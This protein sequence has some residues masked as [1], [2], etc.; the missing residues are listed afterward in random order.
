MSIAVSV[1]VVPSLLLSRVFY[2]VLGLVAFAIPLTVFTNRALDA[3]WCLQ[4]SLIVTILV[5]CAFFAF[6]RARKTFH[7]DISGIGQIRLTQYSGVSIRNHKT[8]MP[9]DGPCSD[10]VQLTP[11]SILW[12]RFILLR[13]KL[14]DGRIVAIPVLADSVGLSGFAELSVAC[15]WIACQSAS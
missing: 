1:T 11:D 2:S 3:L 5:S 15:R 13:L 8:G 6:R 9:L 10:L 4:I 14:E 12:P 7:I